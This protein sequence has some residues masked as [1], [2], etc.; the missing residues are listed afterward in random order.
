MSY[1]EIMGLLAMIGSILFIGGIIYSLYKDVTIDITIDYF[2]ATLLILGT[3]LVLIG[4][5]GATLKS[6]GIVS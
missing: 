5:I 1:M 6:Y 2:S 3:I 4:I